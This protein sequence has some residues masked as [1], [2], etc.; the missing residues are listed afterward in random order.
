VFDAVTSRRHY[1]NRMPFDR[2]LSIFRRDAG[3]HFD[4][5]CVESFFNVKLAQLSRILIQERWIELPDK[6]ESLIRELD[7]QVTVR[8]YETILNKEKMTKG[9]A[10]IHRAF[11]MIYHHNHM[12]ALD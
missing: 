10:D 5:D 4:P 9:E 6:G 12:S 7:Q 2:V 11:S 8:E 1:R 3:S